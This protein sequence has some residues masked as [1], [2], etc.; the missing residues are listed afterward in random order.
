MADYAPITVSTFNWT[1]LPA[2]TEEHFLQCQTGAVLLTRHSAP[3]GSNGLRLQAGDAITVK[4][5]DTWR[6]KLAENGGAV[7]IRA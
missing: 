4:T 7:L 5:G 2:A 3:T 1:A 6:Y